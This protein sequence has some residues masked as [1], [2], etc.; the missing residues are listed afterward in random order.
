MNC[1]KGIREDD[2]AWRNNLLNACGGFCL[3]GSE[4]QKARSDPLALLW[5]CLN[6]KISIWKIL[7]ASDQVTRSMSIGLE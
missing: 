7:V 2:G 6:R 4:K 5:L 3:L 1:I